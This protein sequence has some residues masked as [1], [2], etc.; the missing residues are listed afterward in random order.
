MASDILLKRRMM[1][2]LS[3][4]EEDHFQGNADQEVGNEKP[5]SFSKV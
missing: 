1:K 2:M 5:V 3:M 4:N